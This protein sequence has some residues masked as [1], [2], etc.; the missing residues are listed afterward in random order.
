MNALSSGYDANGNMTMRL[1]DG[2]RFFLAYDAENRLTSVSG[3]VSANFVYNGDGQRVISTIG[4]AAITTYIGSYFEWQ[5]G[6]GKSYYFADA[7]R[8]AM[9]AS[10]G[11]EFLLGDH[12]G[13]TSL[14]VDSL[15]GNPRELRY[16]PWG[17]VRWSSGAIP[18]DYRFTGQQEVSSIGLYDY[19]ARFY[20]PQLGRF[21]SPDTIIPEQQGT[22]AWDRFAYV[23][24]S[25]IRY[26]DPSGHGVDCGMGED[27][28]EIEEITVDDVET[29]WDPSTVVYVNDTQA[30]ALAF[31]HYLNDP[32][33]FVALYANP[34]AWAASEEVANLDVFLQYSVLHTTADAFMGVGFDPDVAGNL[35]AAHAAYSMGDIETS[36]TYLAAAGVLTVAEADARYPRLA[37][38]RHNH[39]YTPIYLGGSRSGVQYSIPASYHQ[40]ITNEF[41]QLWAYG[42]PRPNAT[43]LQNI[44]N[45][46]Y[47]LYPIPPGTEQP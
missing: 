43:Q 23:S 12:L 30:A 38:I 3:T 27:C 25:P 26:I 20:D 44:I 33:Y 15:A 21:V 13:S 4:T 31:L 10:A 19:G 8:I 1:K 18:T 42:R 34:E 16:Y 46:V 7:Q 2:A 6:V 24:N 39:H 32:D 37:G 17:E 40:Y 36:Q 41:R 9:R 35:Q 14:T 45:Q 28:S 29:L 22:K 11:V 47:L 5:D